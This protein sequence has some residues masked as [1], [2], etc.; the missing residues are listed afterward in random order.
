MPLSI[1]AKYTI[2][3][4]EILSNIK[5]HT[6][7][8][9]EKRYNILQPARTD[10]NIRYYSNE[11]L[12]I[13]L[14][15]SFLN[16]KGY[17]ISKIAE[18]NESQRNEL[19]GSLSHPE[20]EHSSY[21][22][23]LIVSMIDLDES[24][25]RR[26]MNEII[27]LIGLEKAFTQVVYPFLERIGIMWQTGAINPAQEHFISHLIRHKIIANIENIDFPTD[28]TKPRVVLMLPGEEMHEIALLLYQYVLRKNAFPTV[29]L[30]QAVP[31]ESMERIIEI[32][33]AQYIVAHLTNPLSD[34]D[35]LRFVH[36]F[37]NFS[38]KIILSGYAVQHFD[39]SQINGVKVISSIE[40][41]IKS[42][43]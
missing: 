28:A 34:E 19:V 31:M 3:D 37:S 23:Q 11:D 42:I 8:I 15:V 21:I 35:L 40:E 18:M 24:H 20:G 29:Y 30:G 38:G 14:N 17:K 27:R 2:K 10:T 9:W 12:K 16:Q 1:Q 32:S 5:S 25:F 7:R 13:L 26:N 36:S 4:L 33:K 43:N 22:D 41:L 39:C 6:I